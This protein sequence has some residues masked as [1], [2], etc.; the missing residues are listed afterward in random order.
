VRFLMIVCGPVAPAEGPAGPA[1]AQWV[2]TMDSK[3]HRITGGE[4]APEAESVAVQV[5]DGQRRVTHGAYLET[6]GAFLGFDLLECQDL[7]EAIELV[8]AHPLTSRCTL[9]IRPFA[10]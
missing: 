10:D 5:R 9:E 6:K 2:M 1:V 8:A 4:L 7:D 3:G